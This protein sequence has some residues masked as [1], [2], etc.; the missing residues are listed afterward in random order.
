MTA[1]ATVTATFA[2]ASTTTTTTP[3]G[4][5][6]TTPAPTTTTTTTPP[7]PPPP[8]SYPATVTADAPAAYWRLGETSGTAAADSVGT[9]TGTY[10]NGVVVGA[11]S[12][13]GSDV[14]NRAASFDGV[15]DSVS[16]PSSAALSPTGAVTV[17]AWVRPTVKPAAG[18]FASVVSKADAYSIQFNGPQL[19][20]TTIRGTTRRRVQAPAA[21]V[22]AGQTYHVV[23]TFDGTT[24]RLYVNGVQVASGSFPGAINANTK[25]VVLGSWE[26]ATEFLA[27]RIDDVAVYARVLTP[28]QIANHYNRGRA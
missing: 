4:S 1:D 15:N 9:G 26:T 21:A 20:F 12:L 11:A 8:P 2:A 22:V 17:E 25:S 14:T 23:G 7:P 13:L 28:A 18:S 24:Q 5:S 10:R 19:E 3:P 16:V 6:T 27:G